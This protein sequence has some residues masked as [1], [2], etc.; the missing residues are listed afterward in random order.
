VK[1]YKAILADCPWSFRT[2]G[3]A[4]AT[5]HRTAIDHYPVM[6]VEDLKAL[7]VA[8]KADKDCALFMWVVGANLADAWAVGH[9]W[10]FNYKTDVFFWDKGSIGMGYWSRKEGEA[11]WLW[12][13]GKP[14]RLHADVRQII[15]EPRREHSRKPDAQYSRI[16]RLVEGPYLEMFSRTT[17]PGWDAWGNDTGRFNHD[18]LF[19]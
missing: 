16:E 18:T 4:D 1:K 6:S 19:G 2:Y 8:E 12:T 10:G 14:K 5:P 9:A 17:V 15:R 13:K 11:C 3:G 7:P